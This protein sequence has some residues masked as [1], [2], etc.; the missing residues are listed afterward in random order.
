MI[1]DYVMPA[2]DIDIEELKT[3]FDVNL[4]GVVRM[5]Q[6]FSTPLINRKGLIVN[7][8]SLAA[9]APYVFGASYNATKAALLAYGN[10]LR[11]ELSP[12]R[13]LPWHPLFS[14]EVSC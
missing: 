10:T 8:G 14:A 9:Y 2:L 7:V 11:I 5:T 3:I 4:F 13:Y 12:W 1:P 6:A